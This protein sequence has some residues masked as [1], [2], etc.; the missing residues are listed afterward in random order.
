MASKLHVLTF[1]NVNE[2]TGRSYQYDYEYAFVSRHVAEK[3]AEIFYARGYADDIGIDVA[4]K[5]H[6]V[7]PALALS[8]I[9]S[10]D[11]CPF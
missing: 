7:N 2:D 10:D 1:F 9:N 6:T 11:V 4:S 5:S 3:M 8:W